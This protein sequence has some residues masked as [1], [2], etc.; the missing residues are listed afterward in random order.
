[1]VS[2]DLFDTTKDIQTL[3]NQLLDA[4]LPAAPQLLQTIEETLTYLRSKILPDGCRRLKVEQDH[5]LE[6][7]MCF[8]NHYDFDPNLRLRVTYD[9]QEGIN[10]GGMSRQFLIDL[11]LAASTGANGIPALLEVRNGQI[12][13]IQ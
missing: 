1:M 4:E 7:A 13:I 11:C 2:V 8:Y 9:G 12:L 6:E 3:V 10:A 5:V